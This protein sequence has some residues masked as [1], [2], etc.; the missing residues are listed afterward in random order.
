MFIDSDF[1]DVICILII[2]VFQVLLLQ[3]TK[4]PPHSVFL[5]LFL[6]LYSSDNSSEKNNFLKS[7]FRISFSEKPSTHFIVHQQMDSPDTWRPNRE[8]EWSWGP[9]SGAFIILR[10]DKEEADPWPRVGFRDLHWRTAFRQG[11]Q[12][13]QHGGSAALGE[14]GS[15]A[16]RSDALRKSKTS[17]PRAAAPGLWACAGR[18]HTWYSIVFLWVNKCCIVGDRPG[19]RRARILFQ[20]QN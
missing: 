4:N 13:V 17:A 6:Y 14:A 5:H 7:S 15:R 2:Y 10:E 3:I 18:V 20:C 1:K 11:V 19:A 8:W 12:R 16:E 9:L